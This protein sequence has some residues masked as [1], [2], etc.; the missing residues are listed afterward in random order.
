M[1]KRALGCQGLQ[2][3][4]IGLGCLGM[5][6]FYGPHDERESVA[7]IHRAIDLGVS[8]FD[9][10]DVYGPFENEALLG[11]ALR[12]KRD[13]VVVATKFGQLRGPDGAF[14]GVDGRPGY[15]RA[16][17]DA[18]LR[19]LGMDHVDLYYQHRVDPQVPIEETVGAMADLVRAGKVRYLGL[20]EA[21]PT[22]IRRAHA[23]HPISAVQ[24][25]YSLWSR[26]PESELLPTLRGLGIGF[27]AY[28][29]LGRGFL[30]GKL[31]RV[32]DL[33]PGDIRRLFPRFQGENFSKNLELVA[34]LEAIA[35]RRGV[36]PASLA[37]AWLLTRGDD[38][39]ALP[40]TKRRAH[41]EENLA[42]DTL[43]L[44]TAELADIERLCPK[45]AVA[46][47]RY[48]DM[49]LLDR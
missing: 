49:R 9:T 3:S 2:V 11:R 22:T 41:L 31:K 19:R 36:A 17:I 45:D 38:I 20:S 43:R 7:T 42:A 44:T 47:A 10:A 16:C 32:E 18:S 48:P 35:A 34:H 39:V 8:F 30:T 29:P 13:G 23:V 28:S 33:A 24:T 1:N 40:G 46:G 27:V 12:G 37:L 14:V 4:A 6:D 5:S 25:E 21:A 15:V 26:E